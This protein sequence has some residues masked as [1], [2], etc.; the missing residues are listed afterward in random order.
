MAGS[1]GNN[2]AGRTKT[3]I[4]PGK[5]IQCLNWGPEPWKCHQT[6]A[7]IARKGFAWEHDG[8]LFA[9]RNALDTFLRDNA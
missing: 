6:G 9:D 8:K 2:T 1:K 3:P 7:D 5:R 4:R